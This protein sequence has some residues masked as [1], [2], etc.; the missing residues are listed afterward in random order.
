MIYEN[1]KGDIDN[2][3]K[4]VMYYYGT[5]TVSGDGNIKIP[6][7]GRPLE[8]EVSFSDSAPPK[9]GCG[10]QTDDT[11]EIEI[12]QLLRP[13]PLWAIKISWDI[14]SGNVREISWKAT[15]V[16]GGIGKDDRGHGEG[17]DD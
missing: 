6:C 15:V 2:K 5:L 4:R 10:P 12:D 1:K 7:R 11:V 14:K 16:R 3:D 9:P 17:K 8:V 13:F